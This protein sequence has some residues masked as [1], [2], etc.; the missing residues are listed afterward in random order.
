MQWTKNVLVALNNSRYESLNIISGRVKFL[1]VFL[2]IS[3][4]NRS[5]LIRVPLQLNF[6]INI[7]I[8]SSLS[9][10][11]NQSN[12]FILIPTCFFNQGLPSDYQNILIRLMISYHQNIL[13]I[14]VNPQVLRLSSATVVRSCLHINHHMQHY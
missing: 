7:D 6:L 8:L 14:K 10:H 11:L 1:G 12:I 4:I 2:L 13:T 5:R 9:W 3:G